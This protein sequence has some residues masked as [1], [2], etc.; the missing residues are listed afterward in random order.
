LPVHQ[1]TAL[2]V[3]PHFLAALV[4]LADALM[5]SG[6]IPPAHR[7]LAPSNCSVVTPSPAEM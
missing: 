7:P 4:T 2:A 3:L 1:A 5:L 6:A